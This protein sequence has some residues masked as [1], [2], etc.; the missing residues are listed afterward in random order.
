M[1]LFP[2]VVHVLCI[3]L[4]HYRRACYFSRTCRSKLM[5]LIMLLS[6]RIAN[7]MHG[8]HLNPGNILDAWLCGLYRSGN[9][10]WTN[11][12][13][14]DFES[15]K[16]LLSLSTY[17]VESTNPPLLAGWNVVENV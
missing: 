12:N 2:E 16:S 1:E 17:L 13:D 11:P 9:V 14:S 7:A 3:Y 10:L 15:Y 8:P 4:E 5:E 6:I